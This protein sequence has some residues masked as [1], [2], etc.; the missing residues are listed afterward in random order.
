MTRVFETLATIIWWLIGIL[1]MFLTIVVSYQ[2]FS[3]YLG[4]LPR[5]LWT[6]EVARFTFLWMLF[7]GAALAVRQ[8]RH[9]TIDFFGHKLEGMRRRLSQAFVVVV[10]IGVGAFM[11]MGGTEFFQMGMRRIS[12]TSGIRLSWIYLAL[13]ASG[14]LITVFGIEGLLKLIRGEE[15]ELD[16]AK[17]THPTTEETP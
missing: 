2:V 15:P 14:A 3:R 1:M 9:F 13:P 12:T 10:I 8:G 11:V 7:L 6:E 5:I 4:F 16:Q 17:G